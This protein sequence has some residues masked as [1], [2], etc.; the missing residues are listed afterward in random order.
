MLQIELGRRVGN[1]GAAARKSDRYHNK[2]R[3]H[4]GRAMSMVSKG[5]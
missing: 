3:G 4:Q 5:R 1:A 2:K